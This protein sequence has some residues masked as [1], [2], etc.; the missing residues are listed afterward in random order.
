VMIYRALEESDG[1]Q[2]TAAHQLGISR[3]TLSR[4]IKAY[5]LGSILG[6]PARSLG[7]L[8][9]E[10]SRYFRG[11]LH[12]P[13]SLRSV[14]GYAENVESVNLSRS[15]IGLRG[16]KRPLEFVGVIDVQFQIE[17]VAMLAKG[18][19]S[20]ADAQGNAGIRFASMS[21]LFQQSLDDWVTRKRIEEG[22][23]AS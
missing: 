9:V 18:I 17:K 19:M 21:R 22:W 23:A 13:V 14:D 8:G 4:K 15:G 3:R 10:Q 1:D 11:A 20:W 5:N 6:L 2:T 7:I 16:V 12:C